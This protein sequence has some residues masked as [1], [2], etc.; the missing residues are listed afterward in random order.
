VAEEGGAT[1]YASI[2]DIRE[3]SGLTPSQVSDE[4]VFAAIQLWQEV[5]E[6]ICRQWFYPKSLTLEVNGNDSDVLHFGVPII[7]VS[8]VYINGGVEALDSSAYKVYLD[9]RDPKICLTHAQQIADLYTAALR[10]GDARFYKGYQNQRIVGV[11]GHVITGNKAP[12]PIRRALTKLVTEKLV[13]QYGA[14]ASGGTSTVIAG[15]V[16]SETT[17]GHSISYGVQSTNSRRSGL[18]GITSDME[19]L[20]IFALYRAPIGV[21]TPAAWS[22]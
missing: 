2:E 4:G 12:R 11:F 6:R 9:Y 19:I 21:A 1:I 22:Y 18:L 3:F 13:A 5:I 20:D 7:S 14:G 15:T 17:D 16:V 10:G 8:E